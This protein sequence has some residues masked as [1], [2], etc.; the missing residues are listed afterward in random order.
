MLYVPAKMLISGY[1]YVTEHTEALFSKTFT[2][3]FHSFSESAVAATML[4][5]VTIT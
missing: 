2:A 3:S 1:I 5:E 4:T